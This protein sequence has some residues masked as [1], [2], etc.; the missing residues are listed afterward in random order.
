[1]T[2]FLTL[3]FFR[4]IHHSMIG[5]MLI[6][7]LV[8]ISAT[9]YYIAYLP[10]SDLNVTEP[11]PFLYTNEK[12]R[13]EIREFMDARHEGKTTNKSFQLSGSLNEFKQ[14]NPDFSYF[15]IVD[16]ETFSNG[17][18]PRYYSALRFDDI[19]KISR[20][21]NKSN[22]CT[23]YY[24]SISN[25]GDHGYIQ[26]SNCNDYGFYLEFSGIKVAM[27]P[28]E[29]P[30]WAFYQRMVVDVGANLILSAAGVFIITAV[31]LLFNWRLMNKVAKVAYSFNPKN[32]HQKLPEKGLPKEVL[33]LVQAVNEM[34]SR[35]DETQ[36]QHNFF[37]STAAHEMRT[38]LTVL[39]TRL[40]MMDE[41]SLKE[42]LIDD[43]RRLSHLVNQLLRLM[44]IG[45]PKNHEH[46][47]D[48]VQCCQRVVKERHL[49][50]ETSGVKLC[51]DVEQPAIIMPGDEGLIE[52]AIANLVDNAVSFSSPGQTV[53]L[54]VKTDYCVS[55]RD[56]GPGIPL[57]KLGNLFEP[58]AKFPPNRNG[59]GLGLAIVKAIAQLHSG[60][61]SVENASGSGA[62]FTL[63]FHTSSL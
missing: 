22:L 48:L 4:Q 40:E 3:G 56:H 6:L 59:H 23:S 61:V 46:E 30:L 53:T 8:F 13:R 37:L 32:L 36:Q 49:L 45:G 18:I 15:F 10:I 24:D 44:R 31:I 1:M 14:N 47:I 58:F 20:D 51:L 33:P 57:D 25:K 12:V 41:G 29:S 54:N 5:Q 9:I 63:Q 27:T 26:Y 38:P 42:K 55:V 2:R 21:V 16:G 19:D 52:V 11:S 7:T 60:S 50:A 39:R 17:R 34:L 28:P 62:R 35:I 43:V